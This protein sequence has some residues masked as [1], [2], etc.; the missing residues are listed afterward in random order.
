MIDS[1][2]AAFASLEL[3]PIKIVAFMAGGGFF[4]L[5]TC[6]FRVGQKHVGQRGSLTSFSCIKTF[7]SCTVRTRWRK[8]TGKLCMS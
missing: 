2:V 7:V 6:C 5:D 3:D 1:L 8:V 4:A